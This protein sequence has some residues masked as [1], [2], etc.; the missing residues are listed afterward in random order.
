MSLRDL[1][2]PLY[3]AVGGGDPESRAVPPGEHVDVPLYASFLSSRAYGDSLT[4]RA[5]L[6]G[7]NTL[8]ERR[9]YAAFVM[10]VPYHPWMSQPLAPL[11]VT[12]PNEPAALVL[13][14]RLEDTQG[15]VLQRNFTTFI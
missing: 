2:A 3:I 1:H 5:E 10:R 15:A 8:G 11:A 4:L 13:A 9:S 6:Y 14:T 12:M 7:W